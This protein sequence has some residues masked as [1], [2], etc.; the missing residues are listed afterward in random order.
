LNLETIG[1][2][3][4]AGQIEGLTEAVTYISP[5]DYNEANRY[6]P[7]GVTPRPGYIR[8]D[9]FPYWREVIN[10]FDPAS[11][12]REVNVLKGVQVAYTTAA[13]SVLFYYIGHVR[14]QSLM[15]MT[16]D[17]EL[18]D[19]RMDNNILPMLKESG[20]GDR[21]RSADPGNTRKTGQTKNYISWEGGGILYPQG[22]NN[23]KKMRMISVPVMIKDELDGWPRVVG[24]DGNSDKLTDDRLSAYWEVRKILRGSTPLLK[25]SMTY[26]AYM[27]G[28]QRWYFVRCRRCG[29]AQRLWMQKKRKS[30]E[31]QNLF[32]WDLNERGGLI[33]E[34]VRYCCAD[35]GHEHFEN[36]KS[37]LFAGENGA[38][39][40]PT[41]EPAEPGIRSYHLPALYSPV[42]FR[43]WSKCIADYLEGFDPEK[44][45]VISAD[46]FQTFYNNDLGWPYEF[47]G[48]RVRFTHVSGHRRRAY[49]CGEVPNEFAAEYAGSKI[50]FMT[51]TVDVHKGN[52]AVAVFGWTV[53]ARP[54]LVDYWRF[55]VEGDDDDCRSI[56]SPVWNRLR[57]L[58]EDKVYT[59]DDGTRYRLF[60]TL[61]DARYSQDTVVNFCS[62]YTDGV[63]PIIGS[64]RTARNKTVREF[65]EW[66]TQAGVA[67]YNITVDHYKDRMNSILRR[68]WAPEMGAQPPFLFNAPVDLSDRQLK[69]LTVEHRRDVLD[70]N[71]NTMQVWHRPGNVKNELWDLLGYGFASVDIIA[72][73]I[74]IKHFELEKIDWPQFW[75]FA[76]EAENDQIFCRF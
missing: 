5:V 14:T 51:C 7:P 64:P 29:F 4:L 58:I 68:D 65:T 49:V 46:K 63:Y 47:L 13:E 34:S 37:Y 23:A 30:G 41:A 40:R 48:S 17:K 21:I 1:R 55:E 19:I 35:C 75:A 25:P 57:E 24:Q 71:G 61:V 59:A 36:D 53:E 27:R 32:K 15:F 3:W 45:E 10:C 11:D 42:G 18:A 43:P 12:V 6:L 70:P 9:L 72:W 52:L 50:L 20:L 60:Q 2:D 38:E 69:E 56:S 8:Y 44:R 66:K 33:L 16:A 31:Y 22:A 74:C 62:E 39:W 28:D 73:A 67:G 26:E 54:F 76:R